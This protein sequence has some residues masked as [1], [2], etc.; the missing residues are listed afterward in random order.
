MWSEAAYR[1]SR[2]TG[3]PVSAHGS[4]QNQAG[5]AATLSEVLFRS[6]PS[7]SPVLSLQHT[8]ALGGSFNGPPPGIH[9]DAE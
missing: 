2:A 5:A 6:N 7:V 4:G 9:K 1:L 8:L 3:E